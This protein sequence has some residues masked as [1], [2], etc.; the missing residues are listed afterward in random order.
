MPQNATT[1]QG[2][3]SPGSFEGVRLPFSLPAADIVS[4]SPIFFHYLFFFSG[5]RLPCSLPAT[6]I[7][8]LFLFFFSRAFGIFTPRH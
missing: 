3:L 8:S 2:S 1:Q 5:V 7:V 4:L 6:D